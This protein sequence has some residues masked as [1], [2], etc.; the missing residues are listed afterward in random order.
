MA[1]SLNTPLSE[2]VD[3]EDIFDR[4]DAEDTLAKSCD[5]LVDT[6]ELTDI[7]DEEDI[8]DRK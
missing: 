1:L 2:F 3:V 7:E 8:L 5:E 4:L 6:F